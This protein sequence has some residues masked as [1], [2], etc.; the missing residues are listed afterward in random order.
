MECPDIGPFP[1]ATILGIIN[2]GDVRQAVCPGLWHIVS[3][4]MHLWIDFH[5]RRTHAF[6]HATVW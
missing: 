2:D 5:D 1:V 4:A 3:T 6:L